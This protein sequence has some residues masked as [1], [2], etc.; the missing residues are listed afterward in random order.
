MNCVG[1]G[2]C[3]KACPTKALGVAEINDAVNQEPVADYLY[4]GTE[5]RAEYGN[6]NTV[7][8][9][10]LRMPYF[11][12]SGCCP[13]CGEAP[14]YRLASQLFGKDMLVAN[15]T[16]CS[17][18]YCSATPST[19]FVT[20]KDNNGVVEWTGRNAASAQEEKYWRQW[21]GNGLSHSLLQ[22]KVDA[23]CISKDGFT[24]ALKA[25]NQNG[26]ATPHL[27]FVFDQTPVKDKVTACN[28]VVAEYVTGQLLYPASVNDVDATMKAFQQKLKDNG[29]D[30]II[31][32]VQKQLDAFHAK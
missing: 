4:K 27:G 26:I 8:G 14:Y 30:D 20:D 18:I 11:E 15:A 2:V 13:G 5:Y 32:E 28:A 16:G 7:A 12:V 3:L 22:G 25:L 6:P 29:I 31:A 1:C 23:S 17:M 10:S 24:A 19:P 21:Y 9:V